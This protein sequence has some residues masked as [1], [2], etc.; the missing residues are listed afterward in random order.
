VATAPS[1]EDDFRKT[2]WSWKSP[3]TYFEEENDDKDSEYRWAK[4]SNQLL[5]AAANSP[6]VVVTAPTRNFAASSM[7][8]VL[9]TGSLYDCS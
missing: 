1:L 4:V 2:G 5:K 7:R 3:Q 9:S 6:D 8:A